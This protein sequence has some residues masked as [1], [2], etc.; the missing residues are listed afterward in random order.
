MSRSRGNKLK[1]YHWVSPATH[2]KKKSR[3]VTDTDSDRTLDCSD[4]DEGTDHGHEQ[5]D[6]ESGFTQA[7]LS[8]EEKCSEVDGVIAATFHSIGASADTENYLTKLIETI[9]DSHHTAS[10]CAMPFQYDSV[11]FGSSCGGDRN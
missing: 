8:L 5:V 10:Q 6:C 9:V 7:L 1:T 3:P 11:R 2:V 4:F